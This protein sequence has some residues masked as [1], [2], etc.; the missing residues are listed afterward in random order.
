MNSRLFAL[1]TNHHPPSSHDLITHLN[2]P[3]IL[4]LSL[5]FYL[6]SN[7]FKE[8]TSSFPST[9]PTPP[10]AANSWRQRLREAPQGHQGMCC[11]SRHP[12][13][14][15]PVAN[16]VLQNPVT[17][18]LPPNTYKIS[19]SPPSLLFIPLTPLFPV[20]A[21]SG[22]AK[23]TRLSKYLPTIPA[24]HNI[25]VFVGAMARGRDDF[26]DHVVDEK[27]SISDYPLSASVACGKVRLSFS[28]QSSP[29][30]Q[31]SHLLHSSAAPWKSSGT[32]SKGR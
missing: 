28:R 25:A 8:L 23:T 16:S 30:A 7:L 20:P 26:A 2:L 5:V 15:Y 4:D 12:F 14:F 11:H 22:D 13:S 18:H 17:D 21:L 10:Q 29:R 6:Y 24:T 32:S 3:F 31:C 1:R 9:S 19:T 27:I